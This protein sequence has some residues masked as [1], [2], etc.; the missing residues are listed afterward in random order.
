MKISLRNTGELV[1]LSTVKLGQTFTFLG[2]N[3]LYMRVGNRIDKFCYQAFY[4]SI[5]Y[6]AVAT[7]AL[8]ETNDDLTVMLTK[9]ELIVG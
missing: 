9:S 6:V 8:M 1:Y 4:C 3:R 5:K 7:G 2:D